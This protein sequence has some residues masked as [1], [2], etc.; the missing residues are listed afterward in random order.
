MALAPGFSLPLDKSVHLYQL[1]SADRFVILF[2]VLL[3]NDTSPLITNRGP[4]SG[5]PARKSAIRSSTRCVTC[6]RLFCSDARYALCEEF[7]SGRLGTIGLMFRDT[8][9]YRVRSYAIWKYIAFVDEDEYLHQRSTNIPQSFV[10]VGVATGGIESK[11]LHDVPL[12]RRKD[13]FPN[14]AI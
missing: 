9:F 4:N 11:L 7:S 14:V 6:M 5:N 3:P 12:G 8:S 13:A 1:A 10:G 2:Y